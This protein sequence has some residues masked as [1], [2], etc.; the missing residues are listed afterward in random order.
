ME[1]EEEEVYVHD[2]HATAVYFVIYIL[3]VVPDR[4][5]SMKSPTK[6]STCRKMSC[7]GTEACRD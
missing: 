7:F 6:P 3:K 5:P 2:Y 4:F 1:K